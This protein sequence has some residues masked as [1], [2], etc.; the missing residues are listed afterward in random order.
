MDYK[1]FVLNKENKIF[2]IF[3]GFR[4]MTDYE[5]GISNELNVK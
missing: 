3:E 4:Y 5:E 1:L 2:Q